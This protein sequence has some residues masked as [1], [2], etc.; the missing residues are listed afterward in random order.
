[1]KN[2]NSQRK[3]FTSSTLLMDWLKFQL[4]TNRISSTA[5]TGM[6]VGDAPAMK[7]A[8]SGIVIH[9]ASDAARIASF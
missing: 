6:V 2:N 3:S 4:N 8:D 1:M 5:I 9:N 7:K